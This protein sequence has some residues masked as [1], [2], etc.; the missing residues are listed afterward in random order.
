MTN[1]SQQ[2]VAKITHALK[3]AGVISSLQDPLDI[4]DNFGQITKERIKESDIVLIMVDDH[5]AENT[6]VK[7][8]MQMALAFSSHNNRPVLFPIILNDNPIP[9]ELKAIMCARCRSDS[10]SDI[11]RLSVQLQKALAAKKEISLVSEKKA[12]NSLRKKINNASRVTA[13]MATIMS[14]FAAVITLVLEN[15]TLSTVFG[16]EFTIAIVT[17]LIL[18]ATVMVATTYTSAMKRRKSVEEKEEVEQYSRKLKEAIIPEEPIINLDGKNVE[19]HYHQKDR[20]IREQDNKASNPE[21]DALGRMLINLEDIKEFYTWSQRQAK[22]SFRLAVAMCIGGFVMMVAAISLPIAFGLNIEM[23]I[24]PAIGGAIAE[25][26]AGTALFV[27]RSSLSQLNHYH[28]ALHEDERFL[29][30]VNLLS[31]FSTVEMQDEMLKE[32]IRSEIQMNLIS[33][34]IKEDEIESKKDEKK[35]PTVPHKKTNGD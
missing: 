2:F 32:I 27:Y 8:E 13:I 21:I 35:E 26:V 7:T 24:I 29:S 17:T 5:F 31:R 25:L 4:S 10:D 30:S 9:D 19:I 22:G 11:Q 20:D 6:N 33:I 23:A 14:A 15:T 12:S 3:G 34:A 18:V 28:K 1:E 16:S